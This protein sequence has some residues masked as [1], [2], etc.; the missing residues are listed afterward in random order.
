M[1]TLEKYYAVDIGLRRALLGAKSMSAGH[2]LENI[3]YLELRRRGYRVYIG[4]YDD[5]EVDF[6]TENEQG[7][8]YFQVSAT[9]RD[10]STLERELRPLQKIHDH[11]PK[12]LLTL[13]NDPET[14]Y[15]GIRQ[16]NALQ[17]L[18]HH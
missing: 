13:D 7:T 4:K 6:V 3:I 2:I 15:N 11:Y 18:I 14:E 12:Y 8:A 5:L 10:E 17:W 1:K 16:M 9:V